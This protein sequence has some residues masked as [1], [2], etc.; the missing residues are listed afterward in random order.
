MSE[1]LDRN[2]TIPAYLYGRL[3]AEFENLQRASSEIEVNVSVSDRYFSMASTYPAVAFPKLEN[4]SKKHLRKLS[5]DNP[6]AAYA[7][8]ASLLEI[9]N[10]LRPCEAGPYPRTLS[11][12]GQGLFIPRLLPPESMVH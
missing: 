2:C 12:E 9:H 6:G 10:K 4:L 11:I 5:R 7:I 3:M 8:D 1:G